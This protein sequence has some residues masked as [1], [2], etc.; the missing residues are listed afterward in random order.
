[1]AKVIERAREG[2]DAEYV[3]FGKV[4]KWRPERVVVEC[5]CGER[6]ALTSSYTACEECGADHTGIV[7]ED[8]SDRPSQGDEDI[9][10]WRYDDLEDREGDGLPY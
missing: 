3:V 1:M 10:P 4:Y 2:Y 7:R 9:H 6:V 5:V 8:L